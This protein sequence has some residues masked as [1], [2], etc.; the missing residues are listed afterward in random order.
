MLADQK[1]VA[2]AN[3]SAVVK[4][5]MARTD[6]LNS[7]LVAA[8][9][10]IESTTNAFK[11][12]VEKTSWKPQVTM[13]QIDNLVSSI[14]DA[15]TRSRIT[16]SGTAQDLG[17]GFAKNASDEDAEVDR[18]IFESLA[19]SQNVWIKNISAMLDSTD[20]LGAISRLLNSV[21][22]Q[23]SGF[24]D[25]SCAASAS[26]AGARFLLTLLEAMNCRVTHLTISRY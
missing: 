4:E 3:L 18:K 1:V 10:L 14:L 11:S 15:A 7:Q 12:N 24:S 22:S 17:A 2:N 6:S 13:D 9:G 21:Q 23:L 8:R 25:E 26:C 20:G 16:V 5:Y 19:G